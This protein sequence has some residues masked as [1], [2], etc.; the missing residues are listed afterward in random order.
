[1]RAGGAAP[2]PPERPG[3]ASPLAAAVAA[4][5]VNYNAR[6]YL[7]SC[8]GSLLGAGL[9]RVVVAD[10]GSSDGSE[11]ALLERYPAARWATTGGN[12]GYGR[13]ANVGAAQA[14]AAFLLVCNPDV[15]VGPDAVAALYEVLRA[16]PAVAVAGPRIVDPG[17]QLYPSARRFPDLLEAFGHGIVGQFWAGNPFSRR[18]RMSGWD[19]AEGR[20][21][22][23]VSG[24]CFLVRRAAWDSVNGFDPRYFMYMEDV[25]LC[26]RL[27]QAG[28]TVRYEPAA[29]VV[30][31]QGAS[32]DRRPYRMLLAH[33]VS[34]WRFACRT[35]PASRRWSLVLVLPGLAVRLVL[36]MAR[37]ALSGAFQA[38]G[39]ERHLPGGRG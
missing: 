9:T 17:G 35:S 13:A 20:E 26:W 8:V 22:D 32:A 36:T 5:V 23:W 3:A 6:E 27:R 25:D 34:M 10:N 30:H 14:E 38:G 7:L 2:V 39:A 16:H 19:H 12:L 33:H 37:R 15:V 31:F 24:S 4:V 1:M 28:W 18:Y 11:L 21:V 29:Q